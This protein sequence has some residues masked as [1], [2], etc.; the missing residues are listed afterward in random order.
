MEQPEASRP[1]PMDG[2]GFLGSLQKA[3]DEAIELILEMF[4]VG[5][6]KPRIDW[7]DRKI[8][9]THDELSHLGMPSERAT[10]DA[11]AKSKA[12]VT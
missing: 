9:H 7:P 6:G 12:L 5:G 10:C 4:G 11:F 1:A 3:S 2:D 8:A